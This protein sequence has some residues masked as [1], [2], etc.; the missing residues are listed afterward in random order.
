MSIA[1]IKSPR[2]RAAAARAVAIHYT[3]RLAGSF[4]VL[5]ALGHGARGRIFAAQMFDLL[6]AQGNTACIVCMDTAYARPTRIIRFNAAGNPESVDGTW[7]DAT[8]G[9]S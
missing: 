1:H 4:E 8:E 7:I 9:Q 2:I 6:K 5:L 3:L